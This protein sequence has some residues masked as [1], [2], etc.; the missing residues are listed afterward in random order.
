MH[1][2]VTRRLADTARS[3]VCVTSFR[4]GRQ[5]GIEMYGYQDEGEAITGAVIASNRLMLDFIMWA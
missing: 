2:G 5:M 3:V 1:I 4:R